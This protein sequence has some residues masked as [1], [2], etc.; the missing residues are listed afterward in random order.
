MRLGEQHVGVRPQEVRAAAVRGWRAE[1]AEYSFL[2]IG[3]TR[4][5]TVM[6][7][8]GLAW[9]ERDLGLRPL[10]GAPRLVSKTSWDKGR[11]GGEGAWHRWD[12][13]FWA[14][15]HFEGHSFVEA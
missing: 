5:D 1:V 3:D 4:I 6:D 15:E 8:D 13:R 7:W 14:R 12:A 2:E 10:A 11:V 9:S